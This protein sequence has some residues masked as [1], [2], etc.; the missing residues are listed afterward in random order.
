MLPAHALT[1]VR[2]ALLRKAGIPIEWSFETEQFRD[3]ILFEM[4]FVDNDW[5]WVDKIRNAFNEIFNK[6]S[7]KDR[8]D[9]VIPNNADPNN[10]MPRGLSSLYVKSILRTSS[11][12]IFSLTPHCPELAKPCSAELVPINLNQY[13][14]VE[15]MPTPIWKVMY[16][17]HY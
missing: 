12:K 11:G 17:K 2:E 3:S 4:H 9:K 14:A 1:P 6:S 5:E 10:G 13:R 8:F 15:A 7:V 16:L